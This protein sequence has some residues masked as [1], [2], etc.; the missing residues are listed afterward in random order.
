[1]IDQG[2]LPVA[3]VESL[4]RPHGDVSLNLMPRFSG[5]DQC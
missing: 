1:M 3:S 2:K 4:M 5:V